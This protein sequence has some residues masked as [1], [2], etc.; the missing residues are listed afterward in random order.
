MRQRVRL[1]TTWLAVA[2][3]ALAWRQSP[4]MECLASTPATAGDPPGPFAVGVAGC[5]AAA[6]HGGDG[7]QVAVGSAYSRWK[8]RDPHARAG[9]VLDGPLARSM[10]AVLRA[11]G[12]MSAD[13]TPATSPLCIQ[14]HGS[15]I[16]GTHGG[17]TAEEGVSCEQ[18]HGPASEYLDKHYEPQ[19]RF[20]DGA[21]KAALGFVDAKRLP[22]RADACLKCHQG[23]PGY[24]VTHDLIAA[25]HPLLRFELRTYLAHY[26]GKHWNDEIDRDAAGRRS[27]GE[28]P[29]DL[30]V[31][32]AGQQAAAESAAR[33]AVDRGARGR[34]P[35]DFAEGDCTACHQNLMKH[36]SEPFA[37]RLDAAGWFG[38]QE[39]G[40]RLAA[41]EDA[42]PF[43][44][45]ARRASKAPSDR[46]TWRRAAAAQPA[47][48][49]A[50]SRT[51][52][53][54]RLQRLFD[55]PTIQRERWEAA[56]QRRLAA[57][58]LVAAARETYEETW[59][60]RSGID[61][62]LA[63]LRRATANWQQHRPSNVVAAWNALEESLN[64]ALDD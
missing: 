55:Y 36:P 12:V 32:I 33:L 24:E 3:V 22:V 10:A 60:A 35:V 15:P 53:L 52:L 2:L 63:K 64:A 29:F 50:R 49:G 62:A 56:L 41:P 34:S 5:A 57:E 13:H 46:S 11:T 31:W 40:L 58:A 7:S 1:A 8:T 39:S 44:A 18:C 42:E 38:W 43:A 26:S 61:P 54:P 20:L 19:W 51:P 17:F 37:P 45:F 48:P 4:S 6:C 28:P 59:A 16:P 23:A 30:A 21:A 47:T 9:E 27:R 25:G 14:C